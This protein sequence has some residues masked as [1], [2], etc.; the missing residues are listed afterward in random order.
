MPMNLIDLFIIYF[1]GGAPFAVYYFLQNRRGSKINLFRLKNFL[2]FLFWIPYAASLLMKN[3]NHRN[4]FKPNFLNAFFVKD[5]GEEK[6][7][8]LQKHIENLLLK[9]DLD[10]SIFDFRETAERYIGLTRAAKIDANGDSE[11][12]IFRAAKNE[13]DKL[14]AICLRR[15]NRNKLARHQIEAR[16]DFLRIVEQLSDSISDTE[17]LQH[18]AVEIVKILKDD[19]AQRSLKKLFNGNLQTGKLS[20]VEYS[21][22]DLWKPQERKPLRPETISTR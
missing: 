14:G 17:S 4:F 21:E 2:V 3:R 12:E 11:R 20:S 7:L 10:I 22:K 6:F 13:N 19:E 9:T 8:L 16:R 15:R 1:A 5:S 18:S